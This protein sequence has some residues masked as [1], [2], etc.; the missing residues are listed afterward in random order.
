MRDYKAKDSFTELFK[1]S[2]LFLCTLLTIDTFFSEL[3]PKHLKSYS[4][5]KECIKRNLK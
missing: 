4:S 5:Q 2:F 1:Y 3:F